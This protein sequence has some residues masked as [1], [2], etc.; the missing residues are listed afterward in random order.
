MTYLNKVIGLTGTTPEPAANVRLLN[1]LPIISESFAR[2]VTKKD[3]AG[4]IDLL[5]GRILENSETQLENDLFNELMKDDRFRQTMA[6]TYDFEEGSAFR[7]KSERME[8]ARIKLQ[9]QEYTKLKIKQVYVSGSGD[10]TVKVYNLKTGATLFTG[11]ETTITSEGYIDVN[12]DISINKLTNDY[13]IAVDCANIDLNGIQGNKGFYFD[14]CTSY[15]NVELSSGYILNEKD[16][17]SA[18]FVASSCF[19][20]V[21]AEVCSD[22]SD[23]CAK[24]TDLLSLAAW[25]LGG[26]LLLN[27]SNTSDKVNLWTNTNRQVRLEESEQ[28]YKMYKEYLTKLR[29]PALM[30]LFPTE[31]VE[32]KDATEKSGIHTGDMLF[33]VYSN[34]HREFLVNDIPA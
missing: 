17:T 15:Y 24:N 16:K 32:P 3:E 5:F 27:E 28:D 9:R 10:Y 19:I 11:E 6:R 33:G 29:Q 14:G 4:S 23:F 2:G 8:G 1:N 31:I 18:N 7:L 13:F 21:I 12:F 22:M 34:R 25:Y 26:S 20:H 30:R